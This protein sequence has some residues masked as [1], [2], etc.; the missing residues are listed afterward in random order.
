MFD[1]LKPIPVYELEVAR[2]R[3]SPGSAYPVDDDWRKRVE[4]TLVANANASADPPSQILGPRNRAELARESGVS[5][6]TITELLNGD[7]NECVGLPAIHAAL[8]WL[9]PYATLSDLE[10]LLVRTV[11]SL[12][13]IGQGMLLERATTLLREQNVKNGA[14]SLPAKKPARSMG[15]AGVHLG[16]LEAALR[17]ADETPMEAAARRKR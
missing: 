5:K 13:G 14:A 3:R 17:D 16:G 4:S 11:R 9:P 1:S 8:H 15:R 7:T 2:K 10:E 6:S 12:D